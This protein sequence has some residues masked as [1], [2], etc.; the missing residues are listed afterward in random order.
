MYRLRALM[1]RPVPP[2]ADT[3]EYLH[4]LASKIAN[5]KMSAEI[6]KAAARAKEEARAKV[7]GSVGG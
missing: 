6:D 3:E 5:V 2:A 1:Y 7:G 4:K